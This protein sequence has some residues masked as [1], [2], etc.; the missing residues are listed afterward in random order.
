MNHRFSFARCL[1]FTMVGLPLGFILTAL[2]FA[3]SAMPI[4]AAKIIP[5]ALGIA[6]VIGM[7]GGFWK[8][9]D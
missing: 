1:V 4:E 7:L 6:I 3:V 5:W 9:D 2:V 8:Q